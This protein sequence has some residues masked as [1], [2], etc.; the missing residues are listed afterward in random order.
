MIG[1]R[2]IKLT[3][4]DEIEG[5]WRE[6]LSADRPVV[7]NALTD[8]NEAPLPPHISFEQAENFA[9][10]VLADPS[11]GLPGAVESVRTKVH[12]FLPGR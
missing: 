9:R 3:R 11:A 1:L 4:S 12:E 8:P 2:G 7:I 6:A 10:S 5:A